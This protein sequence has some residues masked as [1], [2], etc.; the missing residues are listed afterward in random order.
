MKFMLK[1]ISGFPE[2]ER[3]ICTIVL[4]ILYSI[5]HTK[6]AWIYKED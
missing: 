1:I 5:F 2:P 4:M 3:T 6:E